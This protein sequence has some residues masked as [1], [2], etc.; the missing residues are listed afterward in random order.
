M[1]SRIA[2]LY[3]LSI[4]VF[5]GFVNQRFEQ[6]YIFVGFSKNNVILTNKIDIFWCKSKKIKN[7]VV[8]RRKKWYNLFIRIH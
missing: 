3:N 7:I 4:P 5:H 2:N 1:S 8:D 6:I